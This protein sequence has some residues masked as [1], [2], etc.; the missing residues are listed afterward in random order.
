MSNTKH[1]PG[2]WHVDG[3]MI[4]NNPDQHYSHSKWL[5][6]LIPRDE[7]VE[8]SQQE[9][10]ANARLIAAAPDLLEALLDLL[11]E[12]DLERVKMVTY[13]KVCAAL[14]KAGAL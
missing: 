5:V 13:G 4:R 3:D 7:G 12:G 11:E 8:R 6:R 2:P 10:D 14:A 9:D 1:T